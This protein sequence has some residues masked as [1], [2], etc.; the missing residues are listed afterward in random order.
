MALFGHSYLIMWFIEFEDLCFQKQKNKQNAE[1]SFSQCLPYQ[2]KWVCFL[3]NPKRLFF[4][5]L[6][7]KVWVWPHFFTQMP[8]QNAK[9]KK[10]SSQSPGLRLSEK[11]PSI[12]KPHQISTNLKKLPSLQKTKQKH[13]LGLFAYRLNITNLCFKKN[14]V[15]LD[16]T[17]TKHF[18]KDG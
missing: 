13:W 8:Y 4:Q 15:S 10:S 17:V 9:S 6:T 11:K 12:C 16:I 14:V 2:T 3:N 7:Q 1:V 18:Q 5:D